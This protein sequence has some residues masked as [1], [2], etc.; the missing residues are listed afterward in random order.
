VWRH[1]VCL[2]GAVIC[3]SPLNFPNLLSQGQALKW[4]YEQDFAYSKCSGMFVK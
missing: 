2:L 3:L 1:R 4:L